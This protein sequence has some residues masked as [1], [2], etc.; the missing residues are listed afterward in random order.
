RMSPAMDEAIQ[1]T[2][3]RRKIQMA[4][5]EANGITPQTIMKNVRS[6]LDREKEHKKQ[7][8]LKNI[9]VLKARSEEHTSEL[10]SRENLVCRLLLDSTATAI[11]TLSLHDALPISD[12]AGDGRGNSGN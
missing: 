8:E 7:G 4:Y 12:V 11:V 9:E 5:N 1:E 3:R 2:D 10:Q 6:L